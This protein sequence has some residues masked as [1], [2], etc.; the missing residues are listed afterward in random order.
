MWSVLQGTA[1]FCASSERRLQSQPAAAWEGFLEQVRPGLVSPKRRIGISRQ[2][3][4]AEN[5][6]PAEETVSSKQEVTAVV[7]YVWE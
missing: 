6:H 2:F 7:V 3:E 1:G 5:G 4:W